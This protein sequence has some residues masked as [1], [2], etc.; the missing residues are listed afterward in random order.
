MSWFTYQGHNCFLLACS[1]GENEIVKYLSESSPEL[2]NSVDVHNNSGL[3][4]ASYNGN[5]GT[6]KLLIEELNFNPSVEGCIGFN[7]FLYA[8]LS[9]STEIVKYVGKQFPKLINST[10]DR[11]VNA[12]GHANGL[13]VASVYG[14][15]ETVTFMIEELDMDP[16]KNNSGYNSF[17]C[18]CNGENTKKMD[19]N[20]KIVKYLNNKF[21]ELKNSV[22]VDGMNGL[23][24]ASGSGNL[25]LVKFLIDELK[26][27]PAVEDYHLKNSFFQACKA[28]RVKIVNFFAENYST[29]KNCSTEYHTY[30]H[31]KSPPYA[32]DSSYYAFN[33]VLRNG[34][35]TLVVSH[36]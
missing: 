15:L 10:Y 14:H 7:S 36:I 20:S 28:E 5:L 27:D 1:R 17:L 31:R 19:G 12:I 6:F 3:H 18:A 16:F 24:Y 8:C 11:T 30:D 25:K 21:P 29:F 22:D 23:H 26:F 32:Y 34:F 35:W 2:I 4:L 33:P 13:H 9:G